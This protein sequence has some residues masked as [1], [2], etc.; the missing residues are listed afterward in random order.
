MSPEEIGNIQDAAGQFEQVDFA[1]QNIAGGITLLA[2]AF[3]MFQLF[4]GDEKKYQFF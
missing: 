1:V 3:L 4:Q 2:L